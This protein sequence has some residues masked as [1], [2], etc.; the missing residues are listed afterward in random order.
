MRK[1]KMTVKKEVVRKGYDEIAEE[2][3]ANTW[4]LVGKDTTG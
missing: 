3:Q 2:Y 1:R 4:L